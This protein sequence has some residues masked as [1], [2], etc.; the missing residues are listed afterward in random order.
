MLPS[1]AAGAD[2]AQTTMTTAM[3]TF[4]AQ[5][6]LMTYVSIGTTADA[7]TKKAYTPAEAT[8]VLDTC[9]RTMKV[10]QDALKKLVDT[11]AVSSPSDVKY[12][13]DSISAFDSLTEEAA[14]VKACVQTM[15][16][17]NVKRFTAK[18]DEA[19]KKITTLME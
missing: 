18:K 9:Q 4:I 5:S 19:W 11:G 14:D 15:N 17:T 2:D 16:Q 13:T 8:D 6:L 7:Y 3:G 10:A 1:R 12:V